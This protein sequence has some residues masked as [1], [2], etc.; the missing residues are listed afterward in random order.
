MRGG[1][2]GGISAVISRF[3]FWSHLFSLL[4]RVLTVFGRGGVMSAHV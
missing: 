4:S 1:A 3:R 2:D